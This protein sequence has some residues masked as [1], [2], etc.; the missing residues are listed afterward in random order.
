MFLTSVEELPVE[1]FLG[2]PTVE[3]LLYSVRLVEGIATPRSWDF[4]VGL[5]KIASLGIQRPIKGLWSVMFG[6][7][8]V[9]AALDVW[10][11]R[12]GRQRAEADRTKLN[13][14]DR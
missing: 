10:A 9:E 5:N 13:I 12:S 2:E 11:N 14:G 7:V 6:A 4:V 1:E 8:S 3:S